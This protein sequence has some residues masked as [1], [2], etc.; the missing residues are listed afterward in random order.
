LKAELKAVEKV[1]LLKKALGNF[2]FEKK[3]AISAKL[4][5]AL[6][7]LASKMASPTNLKELSKDIPAVTYHYGDSDDE[8]EDTR[9]THRSIITAKKMLR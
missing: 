6:K 4:V 5:K 1:L 3:K 8:E 7:K 9:E 2:A